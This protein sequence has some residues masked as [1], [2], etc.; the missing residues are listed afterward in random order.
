M[1]KESRH[2]LFFI[3]SVVSVLISSSCVSSKVANSQNN[4]NLPHLDMYK[5]ACF[6]QCPSYRVSVYPDGTALFESRRF[7][8]KVGVFTRKLTEK[9]NK[10]LE[11]LMTVCNW[12]S[13]INYY[14]SQLPDLQMT[15]I[16]SG[17]YSVKFKE[18]VPEELRVLSNVLEQVANNGQWTQISNGLDHQDFGQHEIIIKLK[19]ARTAQELVSNLNISDLIVKKKISDHLNTYLLGYDAEKISDGQMFRLLKAHSWIEAVEFDIQL[20]L[21]ED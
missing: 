16:R 7:T 20:Q 11:Q 18:N 15:A 8:D 21:R 19:K 9:E 12:E 10:S 13:Y 14:E 2:I 4:S 3:L 1:T 5:G 6:G 17:H